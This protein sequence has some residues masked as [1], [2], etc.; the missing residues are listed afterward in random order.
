[1]VAIQGTLHPGYN[2]VTMPISAL[3]AGPMGWMQN[4]TFAV[5]GVL[6]IAFVIALHRSVHQA[7]RG[8]A[9]HVLLLIG[10]AAL[11]MNAAFPWQIVDGVPAEPV[12]HAATAITTFLSTALGMIA[13]SRR[14]TLDEQWH[15][16]PGIQAGREFSF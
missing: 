6:V 1:M 3:A 9:G 12:A 16:L 10:G 5:A 4:V 14:M 8:R 15:G 7:R 2:H 13:F 11:A